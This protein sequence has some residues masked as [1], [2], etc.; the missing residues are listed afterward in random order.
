MSLTIRKFYVPFVLLIF[1]MTACDMQQ[2]V[3]VKLPAHEET[4]VVECYLEP[5]QQHQALVTRSLDFF[6]GKWLE[7]LDS[8]EVRISSVDGDRVLTNLNVTDTTFH[9]VFNYYHPDTVVFEEGK[10]YQI[11]VKYGDHVRISGK[12]RFLPKVEILNTYFRQ[13]SRDTLLAAYV[14]IADNP[15]EENYYRV[16]W[17]SPGD[18]TG[19]NYEGAWDD[20]GAKDGKL[21]I[22]TAHILPP[23]MTANVNV[24]HIDK[25]YYE[26][27]KTLR[28]AQEAN[29]NPFMQ[30][31]NVQSALDGAVGVFA[32]LSMSSDTVVVHDDSL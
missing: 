5:G 24:Y 11:S 31:A 3:E 15:H 29:Y 27:L 16:V 14:E 6:E 17:K 4:I 22:N 12:T 8:A 20:S 9:K 21:T 26:F 19:T 7:G 13:N 25:K 1:A 28:Q 30:P 18:K 10:E 23:G 2:N 32:A